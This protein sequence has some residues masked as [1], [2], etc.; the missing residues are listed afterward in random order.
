MTGLGP[1]SPQCT[2][3]LAGADHSDL[4]LA[5]GMHRPGQGAEHDGCGQGCEQLTAARIGNTNESHGHLRDG[6]ASG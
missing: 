5:C 1:D 4:G 6:W 3:D 2:A